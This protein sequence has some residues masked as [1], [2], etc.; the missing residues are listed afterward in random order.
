M[1]SYPGYLGLLKWSLAQSDGTSPSTAAPMSEGDKA[2]LKEALAA[3]T[4]DEAK[5]MKELLATLRV[6]DT[7]E[8]VDDKEAALE[9]LA[10]FV[11]TIDNARGTPARIS[12]HPMHP[13]SVFV[14]S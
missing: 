5:R 10:F 14:Y 8:T 7:P 11:E 4:V 12:H 9:E 3:L 1:E 13:S 2:W 6:E